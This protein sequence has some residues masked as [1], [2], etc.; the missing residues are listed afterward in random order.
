MLEKLK[1]ILSS[2]FRSGEIINKLDSI[3]KNLNFLINNSLKIDDIKPKPS[4]R[5]LQ[6]EQFQILLK[7]HEFFQL[8]GVEYFLF[9]GTLLGSVRHKGF[10]PWDDDIDIGVL[11]EDFEKILNNEEHLKK[12]GLFLSS[13]FSKLGIYTGKGYDKIYEQSGEHH[14][15]LFVFDLVRSQ[16]IEKVLNRRTEF[17]K[18]TSLLRG[19][20]RSHFRKLNSSL[21]GLNKEYFEKIERVERGNVDENT[22]MVKSLC[23]ARKNI[24]VKYNSVFPLGKGEFIVFK[25]QRISLFPIPNNPVEMLENFYGKDYMFFPRDL[26][27]RHTMN[28]K[29]K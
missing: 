15:S 7:I 4:V 20:Y 6:E 16:N 19:N 24:A 17:N 27:P 10:V 9:A 21:V 26:Y 29:I 28:N 25:D 22:Y 1:Q 8:I 5:Y 2:I 12:Y 13:P 11:R 23:A 18:K 3:D 14:V